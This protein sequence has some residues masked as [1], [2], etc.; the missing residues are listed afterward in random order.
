MYKKKFFSIDISYFI[1]LLPFF[2]F[3]NVNINEFTLEIFNFFLIY[4]SVILIFLFMVI[5]SLKKFYIDDLKKIK[6]YLAIFFYL[7]FKFELIKLYLSNY[8][9]YDGEVSSLILLIIFLIFFFLYR[10]NFIQSLVKNFFF[11]YFIIIILQINFGFLQKFLNK[12]NILISKNEYF[13]KNEVK[14]AKIKNNIYFIVID[15]MTSLENFEL[16]Y[17]FE[18]NDMKDFIKTKKLKYYETNSAYTSTLTSFTSV[19]NLDYSFDEYDKI[20]DRS[21]MYPETMKSHLVKNYPLLK[22][23]KKLN[24]NFFWESAP[25]PG[26]CIQYNISFCLDYKKKSN[27]EI[28]WDRLKMN[29]F[30]INTFLENT[31]I[32][33]ALYRFDLI[34]RYKNNYPEFQENNSIDNFVNKIKYLDL[35]SAPHFFLIHHM[36]PHEPYIFKEDCSYQEPYNPIEIYPK[37]YKDAYL[38]VIKK[39]KNF[40]NFLEK[41]DPNGI[42]VIQGDHG[43]GFGD[44]LIDQQKDLLKTFT[45]LK[46][47][48]TICYNDDYSRKLDMIN[49]IR[50]SLSCANNLKPKL[51]NKKSYIKIDNKLLSY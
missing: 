22:E 7:L 50:L 32:I 26:S 1:I 47:N 38:C 20:L 23:L 28:F 18:T 33:S 5:S 24:Y 49:S 43:G 16:N 39:I 51:L 37:G 14:N 34:K 27:L 10:V 41:K 30:I 25:H 17:N 8:T 9:N 36:S 19:L 21:K 2:E 46:I 11:I 6:I 48:N 35:N 44:D 13:T 12:E 3:I 29:R 31:P 15:A 42:V 4:S 40:I 45:L